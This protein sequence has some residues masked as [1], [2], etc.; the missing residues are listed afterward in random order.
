MSE[1]SISSMKRS[2]SSYS[3]PV[4][5]GKPTMT[6]VVMPMAGAASRSRATVRAYR[7]V[8]YRRRMRFSTASLPLCKGMWT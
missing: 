4:S 5:P 7:P 6:S 8:S 1:N 3:S 2:P